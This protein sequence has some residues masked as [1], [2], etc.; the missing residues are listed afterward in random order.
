[1][2]GARSSWSQVTTG[3]GSVTNIGNEATIDAGNRLRVSQITTLL[4]L[5]QL[6]DNAPLYF[7][8]I[9]NG[10]ATQAYTLAAGGSTMS[11]STSADYAICQSKMFA[12]YYSG[13]SQFGEITFDGMA[14]VS[15]V[16]SRVGYF[17]SDTS[18]DYSAGFD[19]LWFENDGTDYRLRISRGGTTVINVA[20]SDWN[21]NTFTGRDFS[22]FTV[23]V[24]QFLYLGGTSVRMG[25]IER[26]AIQWA[27]TYH[28]TGN[29]NST[30]V[31]SPQLPVRYEIRS[32]GGAG[33]M[34]QICA[35][36]AS[37]GSVDEVGVQRS[38]NLGGS[39]L[40]A[41]TVGTSYALIGI[42][43][44]SGYRNIRIE[45]EAISVLATSND[46][47]LWRLVLN[48]TVAGTFTYNDVTNSSLQVATGDVAGNPSTNT[49]TGGA[50]LSSGYGTG[51]TGVSS[52]LTSALRIGSTIAGVTDRVVLCVTPLTINLDITGAMNVKE[53]I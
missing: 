45:E 14:T 17:T 26:G 10:S 30:F 18:A 23:F 13:K 38:F 7:D 35:Q 47:F 22:K 29:A 50:V 5:K 44:K 1:M 9:S 24:F 52:V 15:G 27:H 31:E 21:N 33:S 4:D 46:N 20:Q 6:N 2:V 12:P 8:R 37:E 3:E 51:N 48:P 49:V 39:S 28:H 53:F 40:N 36:V 19:G 42:R 11:V 43:L 32:T 16:T 34:V 25:F 41:N